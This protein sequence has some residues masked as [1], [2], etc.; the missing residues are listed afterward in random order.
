MKRFSVLILAATLLLAVSGLVMAVEKNGSFNVT[1]NVPGFVYVDA[2]SDL[3]INLEKPDSAVKANS[4][5]VVS[6]NTNFSVV[7]E[8]RGFGENTALNE[9]I[10]YNIYGVNNLLEVGK[11]YIRNGVPA[12][13]YRGNF[14]VV[15]KPLINSDDWTT[16][17]AGEYRDTITFTISAN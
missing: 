16:I 9:L 3:V 12:G 1:I 6:A 7:I 5:F 2:P 17:G 15:V 14:E 4:P 11:T 8:S 10:S 13:T